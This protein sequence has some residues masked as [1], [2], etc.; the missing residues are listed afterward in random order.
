M[1]RKRSSYLF[2]GFL[3]ILSFDN[4]DNL[5]FQ[6]SLLHV[7]AVLGYL[8]KL[9]RG[10]GITFRAYFFAYFFQINVSYLILYQ[11][12]KLQYQTYFL[13]QDIK[14]CVL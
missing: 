8:A 10:L 7:L 1:Q 13:F 11:L 5:T 12:T 3:T 14:Q 9:I 6:K 4:P 2:K